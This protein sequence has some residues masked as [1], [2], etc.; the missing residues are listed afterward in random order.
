M[1]RKAIVGVVLTMISLAMVSAGFFRSLATPKP[2]GANPDN[3]L[4]QLAGYR[5]WALVNPVPVI[6]DQRAAAACAI[7]LKP[8]ADL[9][10]HSTRYISVYVNRLGQ[11]SM[12]NRLTPVFPEGSIIVKEKFVNQFAKTP[13]LLTVMVKH[14][15]GYDSETGD[16]EYLVTDGSGLKIEERGSLARCNTCHVSYKESDYVTRT[17]LPR[18]V[19]QKLE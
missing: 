12:M 19:R 16:W 11:E 1:K 14:K 2:G 5:K 8:D 7:V 15:Q 10:P 3:I 18:E 9:N 4:A 17:Y 6:M 13:E